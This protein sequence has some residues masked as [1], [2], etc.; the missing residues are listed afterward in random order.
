MYWK[1]CSSRKCFI[2]FINTGT[3]IKYKI[4]SISFLNIKFLN[5][6]FIL[7]F[8]TIQCTHI[9]LYTW[10]WDRTLSDCREEGCC[11][12][13]KALLYRKEVLKQKYFLNIYIY[14][15]HCKQTFGIRINT[16]QNMFPRKPGSSSFE[17]I[18]AEDAV[19]PV[20]LFAHVLR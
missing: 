14:T 10:Q 5:A 12:N 11:R 18:H 8:Q 9:T 15:V 4:Q 1:T 20:P 13:T 7:W 6:S 19:G 17:I 16:G 3:V 2:K